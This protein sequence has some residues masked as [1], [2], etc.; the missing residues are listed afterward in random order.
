MVFEHGLEP[1]NDFNNSILPDRTAFLSS[2]C[3][4]STV[5]KDI[6]YGT[7]QLWSLVVVDW[8]NS[9]LSTTDPVYPAQTSQLTRIKRN[10]LDIILRCS[11]PRTYSRPSYHHPQFWRLWKDLKSRSDQWRSLRIDGWDIRSARELHSLFPPSLPNLV[12]ARTQLRSTSILTPV[13]SAPRLRRYEFLSNYPPFIEAGALEHLSKY[14]QLDSIIP[15]LRS[16]Y[17]TLRTLHL[18]EPSFYTPHPDEVVVLPILREIIF[19]AG[20][21]MSLHRILTT[22]L[23]TPH[24]Q[25]ITFDGIPTAFE[26]Q[27]PS[28]EPILIPSLQRIRVTNANIL[29]TKGLRAFLPLLLTQDSVDVQVTFLPIPWAWSRVF[30]VPFENI[31]EDIQWME[32]M[33]V[34]I[35]WQESGDS[36]SD[37][38]ATWQE[39]R[40][41]FSNKC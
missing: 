1:Y 38:I 23:D 31:E 6:A 33:G 19:T 16:S 10:P 5:W 21:C 7:P 24:L 39:V 22:T 11:V 26:L 17:A 12:E 30:T 15:L 25:T 35:I 37:Q 34:D 28:I 2:T 9:H 20:D 18:D 40:N 36:G 41:Y 13:V 8:N 14:E 27:P 4:V 29:C 3:L 32:E